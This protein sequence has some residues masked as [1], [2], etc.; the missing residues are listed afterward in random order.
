MVKAVKDTD[1]T[2]TLAPA[3]G[4]GPENSQRHEASHPVG[5][6]RQQMFLTWKYWPTV[7]LQAN[8]KA[9]LLKELS[10]LYEVLWVSSAP[11]FGIAYRELTS[12]YI[13]Y[14]ISGD[15]FPNKNETLLANSSANSV[16]APLR[17][18]LEFFSRSRIHSSSHSLRFTSLSHRAF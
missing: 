8:P 9:H 6:Q 2:T 16:H 13:W 3:W 4:E 12:S 1:P 18:T 10:F 17:T 15:H 14:E 11:Y 5:L 7:L